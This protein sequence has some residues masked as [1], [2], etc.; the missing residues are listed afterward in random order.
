MATVAEFTV[1]SAGFTLGSIFETR[2]D[3]TV[4]LE[5]VVP[6]QSTL[7]PYFWV[8]GAGSDDVV[9]A[10][11]EHP[12]ARSITT[13]DQVDGEILL[14]V[15]WE[16]DIEGVLRAIVEADVTLLSATGDR[17]EWQFEIRAVEADAISDF[18]ARC[19]AFG[20]PARLTGLHA[21]SP[22][23]RGTAY[24]LTDTQRE[25]LCL[26]YERGYYESPRR[27]TLGV[28]AE[29]VG[30]TG[31]SLGSRLRRGTRRLIGSTLV[32]SASAR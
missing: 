18:Q 31:Q 29:E 17:S 30:I 15:E 7:V 10:F 27:T 16:P 22:A 3:A 21:L 23:D 11:A 24:D 13:V 32:P 28:M 8:R 4:E 25:A 2:P 1:E 20:V 19:R 14:R 6:T 12:A 9:A 26:A 5:R